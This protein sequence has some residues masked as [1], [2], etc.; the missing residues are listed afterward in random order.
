MFAEV[1]VAAC[2][3]RVI[4]WIDND[5]VDVKVTGVCVE[6][7]GSWAAVGIEARFK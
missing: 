1:N 5:L 3:R 6:K 4:K 7:S 2:S